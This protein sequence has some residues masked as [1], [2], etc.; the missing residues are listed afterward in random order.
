MPPKEALAEIQYLFSQLHHNCCGTLPINFEGYDPVIDWASLETGYYMMKL[1]ALWDELNALKV[2]KED[3]EVKQ[4]LAMTMRRAILRLEGY[5]E[6]KRVPEF[7][8]E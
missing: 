6:Q 4:G 3:E 8:Y 5:V 2:L 7:S 1:Q